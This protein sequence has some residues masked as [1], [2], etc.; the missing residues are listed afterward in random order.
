MIDPHFELTG[1][2][3]KGLLYGLQRVDEEQIR[4]NP[5]WP[6]F[7]ELLA[8]GKVRYERADPQEHWQSYRELIEQ[9][10]SGGTALG[11][12]EDFAPALAASDVVHYGVDSEPFAYQAADG[13]FHVVTAVPARD[14]TRFGALPSPPSAPNVPGRVLQDPSKAAGMGSVTRPRFGAAPRLQEMSMSFAPDSYGYMYGA[15]AS[16]SARHRMP[17]F[18]EEL[19][20]DILDPTEADMVARATA[21]LGGSTTVH[22]VQEDREAGDVYALLGSHPTVYIDDGILSEILEGVY[23]MD[24][25][26]EVHE[27]V[28]DDNVVL[29][30]SDMLTYAVPGADVFGYKG[31]GRRGR[32]S[33]GQRPKHQRKGMRQT[34]RKAAQQHKQQRGQQQGQQQQGQQQRGQQ[35]RGQQQR[36]CRAKPMGPGWKP[37]RARN[38][39]VV[40]CPPGQRDQGLKGPLPPRQQQQVAVPEYEAGYE[41]VESY[42]YEGEDEAVAYGL[43]LQG[44]LNA[45]ADDEDEYG[46]QPLDWLRTRKARISNRA[47]RALEMISRGRKNRASRKAAQ[48]ERLLAK[49]KAKHPD[50]KPSDDVRR[51]LRWYR[52]GTDPSEELPTGAG[53]G[54]GAGAEYEAEPAGA[55]S[56]R[57]APR[58]GAPRRGAQR[59]GGAQRGAQRRGGAAHRGASRRGA[60]APRRGA[61]HRGA[62]GRGGAGRGRPRH[63]RRVSP[64]RA[65]RIADQWTERHADSTKD[66]FPVGS[67]ESMGWDEPAAS[68]GGVVS[69]DVDYGEDEEVFG[70]GS[71]DLDELVRDSL[72]NPDE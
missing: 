53:A 57:G 68:F 39:R 24:E 14:S 31:R 49:I 26:L 21:E 63:P 16:G 2:E 35:Q 51:V 4:Q 67:K 17:V 47:N 55:P 64:R 13:L 56:H 1:A 32:Q 62:A 61:A 40:F 30:S 22:K 52:D 48:V 27:E 65:E 44:W 29:I 59:R 66:L 12:C 11:D 54:A 6:A 42:P 43:Q 23:D 60:E 34:A 10:K 8:D 28:D 71:F 58:R 3:A 50:Y 25:I 69:E 9:I 15:S 37:F 36:V 70:G 7:R 72:V 33:K 19:E 20:V 45:D 38:G 41:D 46:V 18:S 5:S